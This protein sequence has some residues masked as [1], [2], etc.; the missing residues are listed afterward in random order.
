VTFDLGTPT[1]MYVVA[2][3]STPQTLLA[4]AGMRFGLTAAQAAAVP[5]GPDT[6]T[7]RG[8]SGDPLDVVVLPG[9]QRPHPG[10]GIDWVISPPV[11]PDAAMLAALPG[12][13]GWVVAAS[14]TTWAT[15]DAALRKFGVPAAAVRTRFPLMYDAAVN[16]YK[17]Q[18]NIP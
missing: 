18:H 3:E 4:Y 15:Q 2:D 1:M 16:N 9:S 12:A 11:D 7:F 8:Q 13:L 6:I 5:A 10:G 14:Q 17:A